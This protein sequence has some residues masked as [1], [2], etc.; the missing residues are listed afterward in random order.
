MSDMLLNPTFPQ[1]ELDKAKV[2]AESNLA[3]QKD[4]ANAIAGNVAAIMRYG[5]DH[6]YGEILTEA[7][8][9]KD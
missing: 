1:E 9:A 7:T 6:P 3:S 5:K 2:R 4:D 8:L